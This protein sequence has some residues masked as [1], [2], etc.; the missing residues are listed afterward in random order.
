MDDLEAVTALYNACSM[1]EWGVATLAPW[2]LRQWWM[3]PDLNIETDAWVVTSAGQIVGYADVLAE[4]PYVRLSAD[5]KV[6]PACVGRGIGTHLLQLEESRASEILALAASDARVVLHKEESSTNERARHLLAKASYQVV[7]QFWRV[8]IALG[9]EPPAPEWP[10]GTT[11]RTAVP[12]RDERAIYEAMDEA[13]RDHYGHRRIPFE[14]WLHWQTGNPEKYDPSLWFLA[15]DNEEI[16]GAALCH[17]H[18]TED[19]DAGWVGGLGVRR[20]WRRRGLGLALLRQS[21]QALF[22]RGKRKVAL[23]VDAASLTGATRLYERA[24]MHVDR[25]FD[26]YEKELRPGRD[27]SIERS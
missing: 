26:T 5:G 14:T 23:G 3:S 25:Q 18:V 27:V 24:G 16:A 9:G 8:E 17:A 15:M 4:A 1:V 20:P 7:R 21:F 6:H 12:G 2:E 10:E 19:P 13:F 22:R 11:V